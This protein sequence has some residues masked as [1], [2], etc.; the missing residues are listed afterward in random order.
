M[1]NARIAAGV[2]VSVVSFGQFLCFAVPKSLQRLPRTRITVPG[3][4]DPRARLERT[5][6]QRVV[7]VDMLID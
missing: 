6:Q 7:A 5:D 4:C 3:K 1:K 2:F